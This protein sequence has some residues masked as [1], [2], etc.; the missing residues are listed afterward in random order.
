MALRTRSLIGRAQGLLMRRFEYDSDKA[1][2]SLRQASQNSNTK[3]RD[4]AA[5]VVQ[6]HEDGRFETEVDKL[7]LF[8]A[9]PD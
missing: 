7:A 3:L 5:L 6:A 1:F 4:L 2:D 8:A 9:N